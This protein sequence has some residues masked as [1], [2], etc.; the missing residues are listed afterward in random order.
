MP[1]LDPEAAESL[2]EKTYGD[3][4]EA[5]G[6]GDVLAGIGG[7]R[8]VVVGAQT[9]PPEQVMARTNPYWAKQSA[10]GRTA[11]AVP[12]TEVSCATQG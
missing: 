9:P 4:F 7:G 2:V 3:A 12:T 11:S 6:L 10:P 1:E 5:T 8:L